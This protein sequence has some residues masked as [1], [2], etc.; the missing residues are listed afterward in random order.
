MS[1]DFDELV[2]TIA[3]LR[4]PVS[5]CPWDLKQDHKSLRS[6]MIEE[7]Y[8][9]S[10]AM[11]SGNKEHLVEE[12]GDVLLQVV[13]NAQIL[14]EQTDFS[15]DDVVK[16][17]TAK[18]VRRHP[19]VFDKSFDGGNDIHSIKDNWVKIKAQ[20]KEGSTEKGVFAGLSKS[21]LSSLQ[22]SAKIGKKAEKI[23]FDWNNEHEVWE[24]FCSEIDELKDEINATSRNDDFIEDEIGDVFFT[25]SQLARHL[26]VDPE[27]ASQRGNNK[28]LTR[29]ATIEALLV[30]DNKVFSDLNRNEKEEYW[31]RA[32][33]KSQS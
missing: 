4:D 27:V 15:I 22:L 32:K 17:I 9:A 3:Q 31:K 29:F 13:L 30:E 18:M 28:F 12:L 21:P 16:S 19:H 7:A 10:E 8:E 33:Q 11:A 14:S 5:G 1:K 25:L 24:Q 6:Y 20:E 2:K 23:G 26:K